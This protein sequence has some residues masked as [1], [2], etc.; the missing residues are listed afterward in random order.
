LGGTTPEETGDSKMSDDV[1]EALRKEN[2]ERDKDYTRFKGVLEGI[3]LAGL[4]GTEKDMLK[5][6]EWMM[7]GFRKTS[8]NISFLG[9]MLVRMDRRMDRL[10][11]EVKE[12]QETINTFQENK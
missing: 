10:E 8:D 5:L 12:L 6:V 1:L 4:S 2:E 9:E 7:D 11:K 3:R